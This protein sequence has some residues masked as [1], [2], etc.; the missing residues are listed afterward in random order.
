MTRNEALHAWIAQN[1]LRLI[2]VCSLA[3]VPPRTLEDILKDEKRGVSARDRIYLLTGLEVFKPTEEEKRAHAEQV[4]G[5]R[6]IEEE[7]DYEIAKFLINRWS[8]AKQLPA[9]DEVFSMGGRNRISKKELSARLKGRYFTDRGG[10]LVLRP[11]NGAT[12]VVSMLSELSLSESLVNELKEL[13]TKT[14]QEQREYISK[15]GKHLK[16]LFGILGILMKYQKPEE[17]FKVLNEAN[18]KNILTS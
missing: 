11:Q 15:E 7:H 17:G 4:T 9:N 1:G 10:V 6:K 13:G 18:K 16:S 5:A 12:Q 3:F 14:A 2:D 8:A